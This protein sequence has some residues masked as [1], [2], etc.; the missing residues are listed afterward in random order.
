MTGDQSQAR[1]LLE[2]Y[3]PVVAGT[4]AAPATALGPP[5][6]QL[7][8]AGEAS[9][10]AL[11]LHGVVGAALRARR[12]A[13]G[14]APCRRA[15]ALPVRQLRR[16]TARAA[17][18]W[19]A[20]APPAGEPQVN[21]AAFAAA[22]RAALRDCTSPDLL[23]DNPL[24]RSRLVA[25]RA[26]GAG[27]AEARVAA[28]RALLEEVVGGLGAS[29]RRAKLRRALHH[30]FLEPGGSQE[31]VAEMP[32]LPF[33]TYRDHLRA[34]LRLVGEILW[35]REAGAAGTPAGSGASRRS[36]G[37]ARPARGP[38]RGPATCPE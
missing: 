29:P 5:G 36:A 24:T 35:E 11:G 27:A 8:P 30:T 22:V 7:R 15:R 37:S 31:R 2:Q 6:G 25:A 12:P 23:R 33:T 18:E 13:R 20:P 4:R 16:V 3:P 17:A 26:G 34:G 10:G 9:R 14:R 38:G 21:E 28:L 19:V 32:G 1:A